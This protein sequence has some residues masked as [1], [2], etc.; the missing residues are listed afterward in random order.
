MEILYIYEKM[1]RKYPQKPQI[2]NIFG[3][4]AEVK[5]CCITE[6]IAM[7]IVYVREFSTRPGVFHATAHLST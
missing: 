5:S 4:L 3:R 6:E 7:V 2:W 1:T